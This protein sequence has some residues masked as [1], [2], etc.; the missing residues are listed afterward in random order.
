MK[1][2]ELINKLDS[3]IV[4]SIQ[5][6]LIFD[7]DFDRRRLN[8]WQSKGYIKKI[9]KSFYIFTNKKIDE[10]VLFL[11]ANKIYSPSYVSLETALSFYNIIPEIVP[12]VTSI[13]TKKTNHFE[14]HLGVFYYYSIK[15]SFFTGYKLIQVNEIPLKIASLEKSII[16]YFYFHPEINTIEVFNELRWDKE[17]ILKEINKIS[18]K[19]LMNLFSDSLKKRISNC[20]NLENYA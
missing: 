16:D 14:T 17:L 9:I 13:T 2:I 7:N 8:E 4:F 15:E 11:S 12:T 19:R 6:I 3:H 10:Y 5:D 20:L 18:F 1:Y